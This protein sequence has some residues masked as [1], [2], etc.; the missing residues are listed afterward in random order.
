MKDPRNMTTEELIE[1]AD[2]IKK[3]MTKRFLRDAKI[4]RKIRGKKNISKREAII[5]AD[6]VKSGMSIRVLK[7]LE[8]IKEHKSKSL[9]RRKS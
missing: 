2:K 1:L 4:I 8:E 6:K 5:I 7:D 3:G 9:S